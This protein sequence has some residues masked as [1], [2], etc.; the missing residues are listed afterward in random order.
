M[1]REACGAEIRL[2]FGTGQ[3]EPAAA[4]DPVALA[5]RRRAAVCCMP[6]P[7]GLVLLR[8]DRLAFPA[9]RQRFLGSPGPA[10]LAMLSARRSAIRVGADHA[11]AEDG[12]DL[13]VLGR[14]EPHGDL[15]LAADERGGN[16]VFHVVEP[17]CPPCRRRGPRGLPPCRR[18]SR[19]PP[20]AYGPVPEG[21]KVQCDVPLYSCDSSGPSR[22][23][24]SAPSASTRHWKQIG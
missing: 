6:L 14:L 19:G 16:R 23:G 15:L 3:L 7:L 2:G 17:T 21:A 13:V 8:L 5:G 18:T 10:L 20:K 9:S 22:R 24:P 4:R 12:G 1:G 11:K